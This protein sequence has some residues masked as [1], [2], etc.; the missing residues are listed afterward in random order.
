MKRRGNHGTMVVHLPGFHRTIL[1]SLVCLFSGQQDRR[2]L[3]WSDLD[4]LRIC[5]LCRVGLVLSTGYPGT[6]YHLQITKFGDHVN[7]NLGYRK[8]KV[9]G[10]MMRG[11]DSLTLLIFMESYI[12][13]IKSP[14]LW[15]LHIIIEQI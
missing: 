15:F 10:T 12:W 5:T 4:R 14:L 9:S 11:C 6:R 7:Y 13:R 8:T 1:Y 2:R 3:V